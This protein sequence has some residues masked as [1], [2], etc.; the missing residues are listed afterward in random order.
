LS[1]P[2]VDVILTR[3]VYAVSG[4]FGVKSLAAVETVGQVHRN[5]E[6]Q[7]TFMAMA[8]RRMCYSVRSRRSGASSTSAWTPAESACF[9]LDWV[10]LSCSSS[11]K[12]LPEP[13]GSYGSAD[14]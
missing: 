6:I 5:V 10:N 4:A 3:R 1:Q 9:I 8:L 11:N 7:S 2:D 12:V 14:L 13:F